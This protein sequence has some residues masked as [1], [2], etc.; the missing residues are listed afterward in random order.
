[1][2]FLSFSLFPWLRSHFLSAPLFRLFFF[3]P[4]F[5]LSFVVSLALFLC[6]CITIS[7]RSSL[8]CAVFLLF[9]FSHR[10]LFF[11][12]DCF[13]Q[14]KQFFL[15]LV[16]QFG[17]AFASAAV[18]AAGE[19]WQNEAN[20]TQT[21]WDGERKGNVTEL[22]VTQSVV[23]FALVA[24]SHVVFGQKRYISFSSSLFFYFFLYNNFIVPFFPFVLYIL[25]SL[26]FKIPLLAPFWE[27][28]PFFL[29]YASLSFCFVF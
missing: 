19:W 22:F 15:F 8:S 10:S 13:D 4:F 12:L 17:A 6:L 29:R 21:V 14:S 11:L 5:S 25:Y 23:V 28:L 18:A 7:W 26:F 2:L 1:M 16:A 24:A 20:A 3:P 27:F 9:P